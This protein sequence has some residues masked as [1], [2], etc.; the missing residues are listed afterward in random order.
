MGGPRP[1]GCAHPLQ[2]GRQSRQGCAPPRKGKWRLGRAGLRSG[3]GGGG[4]APSWYLG[5][6]DGTGKAPHPGFSGLLQ[7]L[8][9]SFSP[10][11][12]TLLQG[13][14]PACQP[15]CS[16]PVPSQDMGTAGPGLLRPVHPESWLRAPSHRAG[17]RRPP[18]PAASWAL[19]RGP[20]RAGLRG[21]RRSPDLVLRKTCV[22]PPWWVAPW[23]LGTWGGAG[24]GC[25]AQGSRAAGQSCLAS[26]E[27]PS[28]VD[29]R[30]L[31]SR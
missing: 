23:H 7:P 20:W 10:G 14:V 29:A 28:Q 12:A 18:R 5:G 31:S 15:R 17:P 6:G 9:S 2:G 21:Q 8:A 3:G 4:P 13:A 22:I 1:R 30:K 19:L 27:G 26:G 11:S 25:G 16:L 24:W